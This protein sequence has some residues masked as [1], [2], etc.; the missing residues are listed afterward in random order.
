MLTDSFSLINIKAD[1]LLIGML[2]GTKEAGI[3]A[4]ASKLALTLKWALESVN[5]VVAPY[6]SGLYSKNH[7]EELQ[8][9]LTN[10]VITLVIFILP[11]AL[12]LII[13][14]ESI[15]NLFGNE[16]VV[17]YSSL[18]ILCIGNFINISFG[19]VEFLLMMTSHQRETSVI[20]GLTVILNILLNYFL[21]SIFGIFGAAL[22]TAISMMFWNS[23]MYFVALKMVNLDP[24]ILSI[25]RK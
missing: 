2:I 9:I 1:I 17:G 23:V 22:A 6:I 15:L 8:K 16:F 21:I 10:I 19:P 13:F 4:I 24:S 25:L 7:N 18:V 20:M 5:K 3:Y 12:G 11:F 14:G